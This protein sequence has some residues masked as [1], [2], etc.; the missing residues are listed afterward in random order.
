[1]R[2]VLS[3]MREFAPIAGEPEQIADQLTSLGLVVEEILTVG[4]DWD[5]IVVAR[6]LD[7][8]SHPEADKIQ[9]V[10][11]DIGDGE[12]L[13]ICC[14]A[15]NMNVGDK[16]A[17]A[18]LGTTMPD[19]LEIARRKL[20]G[21]WSNGMICSSSELKLEASDSHGI[22]ILETD[23][24]LGTPLSK[25]LGA[26]T[27]IVF[28]IDVEGNRP[29][30]LS[31]IGITRDLAAKQGVPF[32]VP[33]PKVLEGGMP[34]A[35]VCSAEI[36]DL[37]LCPRFGLR[38][39]R[40][41]VNGPSP[42]W[43]QNRLIA[44]GMRPI[45]T[46]VDISNY[47]MLET[48]HPNH[49]FDLDTIP[50]GALRIRR[51]KPGES[52]R[53][54]DGTDR[55][56]VAPDGSGIGRGLGD[57]VIANASDEAISLAGVM[58]GFTT[59]ISDATTNVLL[60]AAVWDRM[61]I[62]N[63]SRRLNLRSEAS[64][65]FERGVDHAGLERALDRFCELAAELAD[66]EIAPGRVFADAPPVAPVIVTTRTSMVNQLLGTDLDAAAMVGLLN[67]I[68]FSCSN[69]TL[70]DGARF[71]V[72]VPSWRP[73]STIEADIAEEIGR[74]FGFDNIENQVP[75]SIETG[76]LTQLQRGRRRIRRAFATVG[77]AEAMPIPFLAPGDLAAAGLSGDALTLANPL[78]SEESVLRTSLLP[79]L[80][81]AVA[82]NASHRRPDVR[83]FE[84]GSVY[85]PTADGELPDEP[86]QV[87]AILGQTDATEAVRLLR[88]VA[89][90]LG[91]DL[92]V[93]NAERAG[94]HPTRAAEVIFRGK[95]I[96]EVGEVD[97]A[98]AEAFEISG[99]VGWVQLDVA[100]LAVG[101]TA[102]PKAKPVSRFPSS[103]LDLAFV[104]PGEV[105]ASAVHDSLMKAG[106][107]LVQSVELFDVFRSEQLGAD[108]RSL[109]FS[110][111]L[112]ADDRTLSDEDVQSTRTKMI[113]EVTKRHKAEL[114]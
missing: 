22:M 106:R 47:V 80:L 33:S 113:N 27:D 35:A 39:L 6:V 51:A 12:A 102:V 83:L 29:D 49:T 76:E 111:R 54:L 70:S 97:P 46:V 34:A 32:V 71:D 23:A 105:E 37:D 65:R 30:A 31:V 78:V 84:L 63:T 36:V 3:W 91:L 45:S 61:S 40:N 74:H 108:R 107:P 8:R 28:D 99:R 19:G 81:K 21:E 11:V 86:E 60:E 50:G 59:E 17:L 114:R 5:G 2:A 85:H 18:T 66:A 38:V 64:T 48:G 57:G 82:Y 72:T 89:Q 92:R 94:L 55:S 100:A 9:L 15:F 52:L 26:V 104:V 16:V 62:A 67:P 14:G 1:M 20:R 96:G 24:E 73:D 7:L 88:G 112:Q 93:K 87:A 58:G 90:S 79:G 101:L 110:V 44:A 75:V 69:P 53:T 13:Q 77:C 42:V 98:V 41:V 43:M 25:A 10:D 103:D 109:A 56:L 95:T 68:G 4:A